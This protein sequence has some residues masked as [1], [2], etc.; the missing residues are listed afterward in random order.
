MLKFRKATFKDAAEISS[1]VNSAYR[2][3][4]SQKG[5]TTEEHL[6]DGLR[7]NT[8]KIKNMIR[9]D[10]VE[11]AFNNEGH[12]VGCVYL[13]KRKDVLY[14]G[15]L[16]VRPLIQTQGIGKALMA[17]A[18]VYAKSQG[19][20]KIKMTVIDSRAELIAFY[21]RRGFVFTGQF[22]PFPTNDPVFGISKVGAL[23]FKVF[24]KLL[25]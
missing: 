5:W 6:L 3:E 8:N 4:T 19:I 17:E 15:M 23:R 25:S 13:E 11:L 7:T 2:G 12:M 22:E 18:E 14:L 21:E 10:H 20:H 24:E 9:E 16:T 1:L